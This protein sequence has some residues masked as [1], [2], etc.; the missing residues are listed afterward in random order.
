MV[1]RISLFFL[2]ML[3][4]IPAFVHAV[5]IAKIR[6][7]YEMWKKYEEAIDT[8]EYTERAKIRAHYKSILRFQEQGFRK[9]IA[10]ASEPAFYRHLTKEVNNFSE[11]EYREY[12]TILNNYKQCIERINGTSC[13]RSELLDLMAFMAKDIRGDTTL[14]EKIVWMSPAGKMSIALAGLALVVVGYAIYDE[15]YG[16]DQC[17]D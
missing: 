16:K 17:G 3:S 11:D 10:N 4:I 9:H 1:N 13:A 15:I 12:L 14:F 8:A 2:C 6:K 5:D 7:E